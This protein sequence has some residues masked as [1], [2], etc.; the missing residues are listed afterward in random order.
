MDIE[1]I[2]MEE[3]LQP[4]SVDIRLGTEFTLFTPKSAVDVEDG[5]SPSDTIEIEDNTIHIEPNSFLL[6]NSVEEIKIPNDLC[7][8]LRGRSSIGRLGLE[9]HSTAGF[10]DS[11]FQGDIVYEI[12]NKGPAPVELHSG[13]R[14]AQLTFHELSSRCEI[15]YGEKENNKYQNQKGA[16]QSKI[17]ED[18]G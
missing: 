13:M 12:Y 1:P 5:L 7:A 15:A 6:A 4:S 3:Q 9:V 16:V 14:V 17:E 2:D 8:E 11:G 18:N 10:I